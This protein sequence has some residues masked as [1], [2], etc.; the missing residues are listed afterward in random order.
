[1]FDKETYSA[2][3]LDYEGVKNT[4]ASKRTRPIYDCCMKG[5][6]C[7]NLSE[8]KFYDRLHDVFAVFII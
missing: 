5:T 8:S 3:Y 7:A 4:D 6:T 1:M 2:R